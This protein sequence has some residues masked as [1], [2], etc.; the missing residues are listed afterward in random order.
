MCFRYHKSLYGY[1][2]FVVFAL[3]SDAGGADAAYT[4]QSVVTEIAASHITAH[5]TVFFSMTGTSGIIRRYV[6]R[7]EQEFLYSLLKK[8]YNVTYTDENEASFYINCEVLFAE[9]YYTESGLNL[10]LQ[11]TIL[12]LPGNEN[13]LKQ[14]V[15]VIVKDSVEESKQIDVI[16]NLNFLIASESEFENLRLDDNTESR[17]SSVHDRDMEI[18]IRARFPYDTVTSVFSVRTDTGFGRDDFRIYRALFSYEYHD[19]T[20]LCGVY[21][22]KFGSESRFLNA[23][24]EHL[25]FNAG[26]LFDSNITGLSLTK[27]Y[28]N[29]RISVY[30]GANRNP[31]MAVAARWEYSR[32]SRSNNNRF[33]VSVHGL[34][35]N[36]D[37][38][39]NDIR[40]SGGLELTWQQ[41]EK[42]FMYGLF[43]LNFFNGAGVN[44]K[45]QVIP[46]WGEYEYSITGKVIV[47]GG[48]LVLHENV[49]DAK[50][51]HEET[52]FQEADYRLSEHWIP[53]LQ[54]KHTGI[55]GFWENNYTLLMYFFP[56]HCLSD[57][58]HKTGITGKLRYID[59]KTGDS[60]FF[61]GMEGTIV[62]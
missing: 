18:G 31:S 48:Y 54:F 8:G 39:Y 3:L 41:G 59:T 21:P 5:A 45:R 9:S 19:A 38:D 36:R 44:I 26:I 62:F 12:K 47:K 35:V 14:Q 56:T 22:L 58:I 2:M 24:V 51:N 60:K 50:R 15:S 43:G 57:R 10:H 33:V 61:I 37:D 1:A 16:A 6:D 25:F 27:S 53:G 29:N 13:I 32:V 46:M 49:D 55:T 7:F 4:P 34:Y 20:V 40:E 23:S 17:T 28:N 30:G 52:V 42:F 11:I